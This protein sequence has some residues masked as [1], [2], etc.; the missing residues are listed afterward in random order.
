MKPTLVTDP[1][2]S[3]SHPHP[4]GILQGLL[5]PTQTAK[6]IEPQ[7]SMLIIP[8]QNIQI[9]T[10]IPSGDHGDTTKPATI[11]IT[12]STG[13]YYSDIDILDGHTGN[14]T[15]FDDIAESGDWSESTEPKDNKWGKLFLY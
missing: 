6:P 15:Y 9:D 5:P 4:I 7:D 10:Y 1:P 3:G 8:R 14:I 2:P 13:S 12:N 11:Y